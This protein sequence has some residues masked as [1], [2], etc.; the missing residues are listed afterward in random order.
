[1]PLGISYFDNKIS[2]LNQESIS[3]VEIYNLSGK[4]EWMTNLTF[5]LVSLKI[6]ILTLFL[7]FA[8]AIAERTTI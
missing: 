6:E 8:M 4:H 5:Y 3:T 1:M 7:M 2:V